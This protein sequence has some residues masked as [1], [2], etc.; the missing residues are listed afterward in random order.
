MKKL[1]WKVEEH[2][3]TDRTPLGNKEFKNVIATLN[4]QAPRRWALASRVV[5]SQDPI[6]CLLIGWWH[7]KWLLIYYSRPYA[8]NTQQ[9]ARN[10]LEGVF[11]CLEL[12]LYGIRELESSVCW[13]TGVHQP[14]W[15]MLGEVRC[16]RLVQ[17]GRD[18]WAGKWCLC[19]PPH[20]VGC[21]I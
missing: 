2:S 18:W 9:K 17:T 12:C 19:S 1:G 15:V 13:T 11:G 8:I 7:D 4:P 5:H 14:G 6:Y 16:G 3:F 10:A 21:L 20:L